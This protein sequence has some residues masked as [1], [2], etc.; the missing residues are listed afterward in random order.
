M[1]ILPISSILTEVSRYL[2]MFVEK[3]KKTKKMEKMG[4]IRAKLEQ[5]L[6]R[7]LAEVE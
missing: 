7:L 5:I 1:S 3:L 6:I 4:K 2:P